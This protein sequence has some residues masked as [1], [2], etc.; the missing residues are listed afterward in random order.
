[1]NMPTRP[2]TLT[3]AAADPGRPAQTFIII[4]D[5]QPGQVVHVAFLTPDQAAALPV[6]PPNAL[7][8][9][10]APAGGL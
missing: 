3:G 5:W 10:V 6:I 1:M 2:D 8:I 4:R 9:A 7:Q